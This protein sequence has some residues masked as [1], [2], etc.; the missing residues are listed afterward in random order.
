MN[1]DTHHSSQETMDRLNT[2]LIQDRT[3][4]AIQDL[5]ALQEDLLRAIFY[6]CQDRSGRAQAR[7]PGGWAQAAPYRSIF[8]AP[9]YSPQEH[10]GRLRRDPCVVRPGDIL[11]SGYSARLR[12]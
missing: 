5:P 1:D 10:P 9:C 4:F 2:V 8:F 3:D 6:L 11:I 7:T 12:C